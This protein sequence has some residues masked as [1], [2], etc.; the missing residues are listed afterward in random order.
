MIF[1]HEHRKPA[2]ATADYYDFSAEET[3]S[4]LNLQ[5]GEGYLVV[6]QTRV[7]LKVMGSAEEEELFNTKPKSE[8]RD[9]SA[10][11]GSTAATPAYAPA[12]EDLPDGARATARSAPT[13]RDPGR[14]PGSEDKAWRPYASEPGSEDDA[15]AGRWPQAHSSKPPPLRFPWGQSSTRVYAFVGDGAAEAAAKVA[16]LFADAAREEGAYVLAVD[17][18]GGDLF[19]RLSNEEAV[20][21]DPYLKKG[22]ADLERLAPHVAP[23]TGHEAMMAVAPPADEDLPAFALIEAAKEI[24]DVCV[25]TCALEGSYASDWLHEAETVVGCSENDEAREALWSA[26]RAEELR[27]KNGTLLCTAAA[28]APSPPTAGP[29]YEP[30]VGGRRLFALGGEGGERASLELAGALVASTD[31]STEGKEESS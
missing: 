30:E 29:L 20:T 4:L 1:R 6:G 22:E 3:D 5:A 15:G 18:A 19:E 16:G 21:P 17:A 28:E 27:G 23:A 24:F 26:S 13:L 25:V 8:D 14:G 11:L 9:G 31:A 10:A 7:P 12:R 2:Q